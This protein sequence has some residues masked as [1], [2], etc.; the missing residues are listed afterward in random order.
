MFS[1]EQKQQNGSEIKDV[2]TNLIVANV[3]Q[4]VHV[5]IHHHVVHV[6]LPQ[7]SMSVLCQ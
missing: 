2:L 4:Y 6:K 5:S 3:S 7:C 1:F